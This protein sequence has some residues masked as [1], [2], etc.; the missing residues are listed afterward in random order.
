MVRGG[1]LRRLQN[2]FFVDLF[3]YFGGGTHYIFETVRAVRK[4][5]RAL[6]I[7]MRM[8]SEETVGDSGTVRAALR[9][10]LNVDFFL[11]WGHST[12][13]RLLAP[14]ASWRWGVGHL[15]FFFWFG[16]GGGGGTLGHLWNVDFGFGVCGWALW[17]F[18]KRGVGGTRSFVECWFWIRSG[19][20]TTD[21][22][23]VE[24]YSDDFQLW[25]GVGGGTSSFA[26]C[27]LFIILLTYLFF[28]EGGG[29]H[30]P[31]IWN[32]RHWEGVGGGTLRIFM[33][34]YLE[35]TGTLRRL[36]NV[37]FFSW[38]V[39]GW[40][41]IGRFEI[42]GTARK[43]KVGGGA[44]RIVGGGGGGGGGGHSAICRMLDSEVGVGVGTRQI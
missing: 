19:V 2:V 38:V 34:M 10:L 21:L 12:D 23:F 1:A 35:E 43:L 14:P 27:Y 20:D 11:G 36:L 4:E 41:A 32:Y 29:V 6:R 7:F 28:L 40:V 44:L 3:I 22:T 30:S 8:H 16:G 18:T 25:D 15:E 17:I 42:V 33:R 13:L 26:E 37:D 9:R 39:V 24:C 5:G 31:Q